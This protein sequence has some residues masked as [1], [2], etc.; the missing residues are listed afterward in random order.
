MEKG[1]KGTGK[2]D[3]SNMFR[4]RDRKARMSKKRKAEI[5]EEKERERNRDEKKFT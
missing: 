2:S 5:W 1:D 4:L 3:I